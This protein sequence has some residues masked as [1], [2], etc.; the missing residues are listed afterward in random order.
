MTR[1][2]L[3]TP[4]TLQLV[5]VSEA[6]DRLALSVRSVWGLIAAGRLPVVRLGRRATRIDARDLAR[7]VEAGRS[8]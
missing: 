4:D 2:T 1:A 6:A 3:P 5:T 7:L 8:A